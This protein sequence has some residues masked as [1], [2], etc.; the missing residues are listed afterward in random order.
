MM[1]EMLMQS[2]AIKIDGVDLERVKKDEERI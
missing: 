2:Y 1:R